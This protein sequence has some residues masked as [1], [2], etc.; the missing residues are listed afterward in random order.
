MVRGDGGP[1]IL[2]GLRRG[3]LAALGTL[4][5]ILAALA[6]IQS[7]QRW[8]DPIIDTGRDLYIPE[9]LTHGARLYRDIRYQ[10]PPLAPYLLAAITSVIGHSLPSYTAIGLLQ[11][12]LI[13]YALWMIGRRTAGLLGGFAAALFFIALSFCGASTWGAN[14]LFPY[15][16]GATIGMAFLVIS[17]AFFLYQRPSFALIALFAAS[18]C[19]VEYAVAAV[20]VIAILAAA[21]RIT[22][23]HMLSF[24][25]AEGIAVA[26]AL[27]YFPNIRENVFAEA[28]TRGES[29]RRFFSS[30]S[31][32]ADWRENLGTALLAIAGIAAIVWLLRSVRPQIA[33]PLVMVVSVFLGSHAFFRA[34]AILQLVA[35]VQGFR[36]RNATL[37][38]LSAFSIASTLRIPL[39]VS[40]VWYGFVLIVPVY[41]L[42]AYVL[43]AYL[44]L[45]EKAIWWIPL[46]ALLCGRDLAEQRVR[47]ALKSFAIASPRGS[48]YDA[49]PDRARVL[50]AFIGEIHG[51]TLA[52]LPEGIT[53]NYLTR[54]RTSLTFHTFTPVETAAPRV[55]A[56]IISEFNA[57]PPDRVAIVSRDVSEYGFRGFGVDYDQRL[58]AWLT[59]KYSVERRWNE[60]RFQLYLLT[61]RR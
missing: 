56:S 8:L 30:V 25:V 4:L 15:S 45:G 36:E 52:V 53:L 10:Y 57:R 38:T 3:S 61:L 46:I 12:I 28:L 49:N 50:N 24:I 29:A 35:L 51:G 2:S 33:I 27:L 47:Y 23:R 5:L 7:Y 58:F 21:R 6:F 17:L 60:P 16:Y 48:F 32:M 59:E 20:V 14:F 44:R 13:A 1:F 19:K 54:T 43:F 11:S 34:W 40:P 22:I 26:A 37:L 42:I 18:W 55:E 9:Q 39:S 41:A 31:G